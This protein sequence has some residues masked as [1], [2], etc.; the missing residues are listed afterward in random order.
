[1]C[2]SVGESRRTWSRRRQATVE[3][4]DISSV[5]DHGKLSSG[6]SMKFELNIG[7]SF[8]A[9]HGSNPLGIIW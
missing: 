2:V 7:F 4:A 1:V 5:F 9:E 8:L 6:G 3:N